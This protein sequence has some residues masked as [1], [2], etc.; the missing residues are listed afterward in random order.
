MTDSASLTTS[1]TPSLTLSATRG[2]Q[3]QSKTPRGAL[4]A[5]ARAEAA[6]EEKEEEEEGRRGAHPAAPPSAPPPPAHVVYVEPDVGLPLH[7]APVRPPP[8]PPPRALRSSRHA[9]TQL[10]VL[11]L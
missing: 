3:P 10:N 6:A 9:F 5:R 8:A 4:P 2:R 7:L 1:T 11:W